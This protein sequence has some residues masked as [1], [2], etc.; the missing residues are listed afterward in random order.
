MFAWYVRAA[1]AGREAILRGATAALAAAALTFAGCGGGER[2]D[3]DD[4][5]GTFKVD[6]TADFP[7]RQNLADETEMT[8]TVKNLSGRRIPNLA[9]TIESQGDGSRAAAFG[10]LDSTPGLSS[11]SRPVWIVDDGPYNGAT[12]YT[13]TWALGPVPAGAE[14][15]F[16]W[17]VTA[18][19]PGR[20]RLTYR[21]AGSLGRKAHVVEG[22]GEPADGSF[23]VVIGSRPAQ[24]RVAADGD[25]VRVPAE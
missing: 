4:V 3:E 16:V 10:T 14:R 18:T 6:V 5:A 13:D 21:L 24:A 11:S 19:K 25:V 15:D 23:D 9:A 2:Q 17:R 1:V 22:D 7:A 20:Y 12:A 8:I